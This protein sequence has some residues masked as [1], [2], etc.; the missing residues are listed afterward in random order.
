[1]EKPTLKFL[2][3]GYDSA[4]LGAFNSMLLNSRYHAR[5]WYLEL[6]RIL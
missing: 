5:T 6:S 4:E 1:M 3:D 2:L